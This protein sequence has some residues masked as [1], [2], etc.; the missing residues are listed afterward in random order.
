MGKDIT[1]NY[2]LMSIEL[3]EDNRE[4]FNTSPHCRF[5]LRD[6]DQFMPEFKIV[7]EFFN[8]TGNTL[9]GNIL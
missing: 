4:I 1:V 5:E 3:T 8:R 9:T 6:Y 7:L 2:N